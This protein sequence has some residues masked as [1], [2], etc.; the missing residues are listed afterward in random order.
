MIFVSSARRI[1]FASSASIAVLALS[2]CGGGGGSSGSSAPTNAA[3]QFTSP[4]TAS[5]VENTPTALTLTASDA[6][7]DAVTFAVSGGA[8]SAAFVVN[9]TSLVFR[10][11]ADFERPTD[12][13]RDN[14]YTLTVA[15]R[16]G[17]GGSTSID[18]V[19][20]VNNSKEGIAVTRV[21]TGFANPAGL[22]FLLSLAP[23]PPTAGKIA[24]AQTDGHIFEVDGTTGARNLLSDVF[25]GRPRGRLLAVTYNTR[26][27]NFYGGLYAVAQ[28]P[29]GRVFL[30]RYTRTPLPELEILPSGS[31]QVS[32]T[33]FN[34]PE[35]GLPGGDLFMTLSDESGTFAQNPT[36]PLGKLIFLEERDPFAGASVSSGGHTVRIIGAGIR[37][38]GGAGAIN[39]E[40]LLSDQGGSLEQELTS[41]LPDARPLDFGWPGRE[42]TQGIGSNPPAAINGPRVAYGFGQTLDLGTGV[43]FGGIYRGPIADLDN[44]FVFGDRGGGIWSIRMTDLTS[45][46]LVGPRQMD[47]RIFDFVP[48]AGRIESPIA[49]IIDDLNRMFIFDSD[50]ELFRVDAA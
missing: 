29:D 13:N 47:R 30:Q 14:V 18:L 28:E 9:G 33:L 50:G 42:G 16:D 8:D 44:R 23:A 46:F 45:G 5:V 41:F 17:R 4:A 10:E 31:P 6:N 11:T 19:I 40:I 1:A 7:G 35:R 20:T 34:G 12:T 48:D 3:P 26:R 2:G 22:G 36:S 27:N 25:A 32:A 43:V 21:A 49:F 15:A 38:S 24:V 37:R 39:G